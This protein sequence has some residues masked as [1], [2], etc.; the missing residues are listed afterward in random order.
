MWNLLIKS[1]FISLYMHRKFKS[2]VVT[3]WYTFILVAVFS[4]TNVDFTSCVFQNWYLFSCTYESLFFF[5]SPQIQTPSSLLTPSYINKVVVATRSLLLQVQRRN[6]RKSGTRDPFRS[7][8]CVHI[9]SF[10]SAAAAFK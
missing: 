2:V 6:G 8:S 3:F 4:V 1:I 5:P 10:T 7:M 9:S